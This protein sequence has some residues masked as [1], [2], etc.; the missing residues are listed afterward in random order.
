MKVVHLDEIE[1]TPI[2]GVNWKPLRATLGVRAFGI[3]AYTAEPGEL[4]V[5]EHTE[6]R[7]RHEEVYVVIS[8]RATF[9]VDGKEV[10]APAG[11]VVFLDDPA[12]HRSAR[13]EE[14]GTAVLAVGGRPGEAYEILPWEYG[15]RAYRAKLQGRMDEA[16]SIAEEGLAAHPENPGML[17]ALACAEAHAGERDAALRHLNDAVE[18][19]PHVRDWLAREETLDPIRDDPRF[20][21]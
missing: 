11:T 6:E 13:A 4:V 7:N 21:A 18:R 20:P 12:H 8:G 9:T 1:P 2:A 17:F 5:E 15:F 19:G 14:P 16:R 10:D 3:N